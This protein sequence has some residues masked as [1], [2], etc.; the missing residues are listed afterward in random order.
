MRLS[1][2]SGGKSDRPSL[3]TLR[4]SQW[5]LQDFDAKLA[6]TPAELE[7]FLQP[8]CDAGVDLFHCSTRRFWEPEF[9]GS[10]LNLA[11]WTK[12]LTG[13]PTIT[14]GSVTLNEDM[15]RS[16]ATDHTAS[17]TGIDELLARLQRG[18]FDLVAIGRSLIVNPSWPVQIRDGALN[19]T[20]PFNRSVLSQLV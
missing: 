4:F 9:T 14:V 10:D 7:T 20:R 3:L 6:R 2:R 18:E 8:L 16:F 13:K 19:E 12:K 1:G 15:T 5:K 11:G 17:I